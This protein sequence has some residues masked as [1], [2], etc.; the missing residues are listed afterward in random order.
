LDK[1]EIISKVLEKKQVKEQT[2][3]INLANRTFKRTKDGKY[4]IA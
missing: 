2:I 3:L 1:Q 4:K